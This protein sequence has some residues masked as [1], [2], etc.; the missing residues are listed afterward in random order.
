M[1]M[2]AITAVKS[3]EQRQREHEKLLAK[4]VGSVPVRAVQDRRRVGTFGYPVPAPGRNHRV[5]LGRKPGGRVGSFFGLARLCLNVAV[6]R[7]L[8]LTVLGSCTL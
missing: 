6:A 2:A 1:V 8:S 4:A 7:E 3:K 5:F